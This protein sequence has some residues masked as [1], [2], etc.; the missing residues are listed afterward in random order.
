MQW[1]FTALYNNTEKMKAKQSRHLPNEDSIDGV[2]GGFSF[3]NFPR[4]F[5]EV[6][7]LE[8][9]LLKKHL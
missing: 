9:D 1:H 5:M 8:D 6:K 2:L 7:T 4:K 3:R